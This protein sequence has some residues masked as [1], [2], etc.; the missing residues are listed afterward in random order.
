[1]ATGENLKLLRNHYGYTQKI[2]EFETGIKQALYS[3]YESGDR[4]V[5]PKPLR[6]LATFYHVST[7]ALKS[8]KPIIEQSLTLSNCEKELIL[9]LRAAKN[10]KLKSDEWLI[11]ILNIVKEWLGKGE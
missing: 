11:A 10:S 5:P 2:I 7:T 6:K 1:M 8:D 4:N 3:R 9:K